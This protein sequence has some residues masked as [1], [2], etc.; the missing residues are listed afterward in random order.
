MKMDSKYLVNNKVAFE[1]FSMQLEMYKTIAI[2]L[3]YQQTL[4][5]CPSQSFLGFLVLWI[6]NVSHFYP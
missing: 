1:K 3:S 5:I 2:E 6:S 4:Y